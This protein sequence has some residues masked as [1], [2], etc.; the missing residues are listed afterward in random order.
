MSEEYRGAF[1]RGT[2]F[3]DIR[4]FANISR[5]STH[6][7]NVTLEDIA[8]CKDAFDAGKKFHAFVDELVDK[9]ENLK[10][11]ENNKR[12]GTK[13]ITR[14]APVLKKYIV[15]LLKFAEDDIIFTKNDRCADVATYL[16]PLDPTMRTFKVPDQ[17]LESWYG[18]LKNIYFSGTIPSSA[19]SGD[20]QK[21]LTV[22]L[23]S[24]PA[25]ELSQFGPSIK[26]LAKNR[27]VKNYTK[28][29]LRDFDKTFRKFLKNQKQLK[30]RRV[31]KQRSSF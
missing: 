4:Y 11:N 10:N 5:E 26:A 22:F 9:Q 24:I 19:I 12:I 7:K 17:K 20:A 27:H 18:L 21:D 6:D 14:H 2:L 8:S 1:I 13:I 28:Q 30:T 29:R 25:H 23:K 3:P 31:F 15:M 16:G